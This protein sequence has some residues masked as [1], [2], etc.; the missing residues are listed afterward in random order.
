MMS[1]LLLAVVLSALGATAHAQG[2][3]VRFGAYF[4]SANSNLFADVSSLYTRGAAFGTA[5]PPGL[6]QSD[7][8]GF[9]GGVEYNH[10]IVK[11]VELAV[12]FDWYGK[13]LDTSYRDYVRPDDSPIL[14]TLRL[15]IMPIGVSVRIVPTSRRARVAPFVV[16]GVDAMVYEYEEFGDFVDFFDPDLTVIPDSFI[17]N[18]VGFGVH[19]GGGL[20][21]ALSDDFAIVGEA[22]YYWSETDMAD[23]FQ[24]NRIDL[25]GVAVTVGF[26][27]RF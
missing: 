22:R 11:N 13:T 20:R 3:D 17:S 14:Q 25:G 4:P 8:E 5:T 19:A 26:H 12:S 9:F 7:W 18:G 27:V 10:K 23:D 6:T 16:A 24:A 2:F 21:V 1:R 15:Q